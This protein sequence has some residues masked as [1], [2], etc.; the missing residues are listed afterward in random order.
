MSYLWN[1]LPDNDEILGRRGR[2]FAASSRH[3]VT[4]LAN[5]CLAAAIAVQPADSAKRDEP[6][7]HGVCGFGCATPT[8]T[9]ASTHIVKPGIRGLARSGLNAHLTMAADRGI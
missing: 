9:A 4:L 7:L 5:V 8:G 2:R 6:E 3:P 1:S